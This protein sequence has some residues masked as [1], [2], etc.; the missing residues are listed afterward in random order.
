MEEEDL[1]V[2][3]ELATDGSLFDGYHPRMEEVH[4]RNAARLRQIIDE[5]GWPGE[6]IVGEN[7]AEAAWLIA[8]HAI[9]E[10]DFQRSCLKLLKL[11][12]DAG[13]VAAW[14][15]A[16]LEDRIRVFEGR[17][18]LYATQFDIGDDGLPV[19]YEIEA[20]ERVDERRRAVGLESLAEQIGRA[21]RVN[22]PTP[23]TRAKRD[24]EYQEW[25]RRVGW[26]E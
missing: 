4:C 5:Y 18:Q 3:A 16:Y 14:Q 21:Q 24:R 20:P 26:R 9:G 1:R 15:A 23:E 7:G 10:P 8:Q 6:P 25:L 22:P 11:A 2:R 17:P 19:P 13:E 12:A